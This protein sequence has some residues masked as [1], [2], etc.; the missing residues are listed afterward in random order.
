MRRSPAT[1]VILAWNAWQS[2]EALSRVLAPHPRRPRPGDG[3]R[4]RIDRRHRSAAH[5]LPLDRRRDQRGEPG[6]RPGMQ[7]RRR[8]RPPRRPRL[9]EQRHR[10]HGSVARPADRP[11]S[12]RTPPSEPPG[13]GRTSSPGPRWPKA[14][15]T[16]A[17]T[18]PGMRRF[19]RDWA[20]RPPRPDVGDRAPGRVLPGGAA[21][22]V[23]GGGRIRPRLRHR[24]IRGRR[25]VPAH[26]RHR[27]PPAHRPRVLR[28][29]R[30]PPDL[31][32]QRARL[33]RRAGV[34]PGP[35]RVPIRPRALLARRHEGLG[36]PHHQGRGGQHRHVPGV[37]RGVRR[38]G[39][40][41]RH[42]LDRRHRPASPGTSVPR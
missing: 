36:L 24:R 1:I 3:G 11:R 5:P 41:L 29:P 19:A 34:E 21:R 14:R 20:Q 35:L 39:R 8:R 10:P 18:W 9:P 13:R 7:R 15:P 27:P 37:T 4:Q 33:V 16:S 38:R 32:R 17:A 28:A 22:P 30:R 31:R 40:R 26:R 2:T 23:R 12:T 25:P 6:I 42:R